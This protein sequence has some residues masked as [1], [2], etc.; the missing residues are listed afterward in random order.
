MNFLAMLYAAR[1]FQGT[2]T[3]TCDQRRPYQRPFAEQLMGA[4]GVRTAG[5]LRDMGKNH[6]SVV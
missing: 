5:V 1:H 6:W 3:M 2:L 4:G